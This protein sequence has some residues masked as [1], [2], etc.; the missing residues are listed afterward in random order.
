MVSETQASCKR[1]RAASV[2]RGLFLA[3]VLWIGSQFRSCTNQHWPAHYTPR[4][5]TLSLSPIHHFTHPS[6]PPLCPAYR[7]APAFCSSCPLHHSAHPALP[8]TWLF[9]P[10]WPGITLQRVVNETTVSGSLCGVEGGGGERGRGLRTWARCLHTLPCPGAGRARPIRAD[11]LSVTQKDLYKRTRWP[12]WFYNDWPTFGD[13]GGYFHFVS[14]LVLFPLRLSD[15]ALLLRVYFPPANVSEYTEQKNIWL[16]RC[17]C[18]PRVF[19]TDSSFWIGQTL[20][21]PYGFPTESNTEKIVSL[22]YYNGSRRSNYTISDYL[23]YL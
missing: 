17:Y 20:C 15:P 13:P 21:T 18:N 2:Q 3:A 6:L 4:S 19:R 1:S 11:L 12:Q 22:H 8:P 10:C 23:L 14:L 5:L 7:Q 16:Q 9:L